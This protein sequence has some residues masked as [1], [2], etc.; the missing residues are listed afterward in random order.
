[1]RIALAADHAGFRLKQQV[2][3]HLAK[4]GHEVI[5]LG[6]DSTQPVDYPDYA[7]AAGT[8]VLEGKAERGVII[9]GSG[10][11]AAV[12]ANKLAGIRASLAHDTYT[13]H[14]A[15]EHDDLNVLA[16]GARVIGEALATEIVD[17][18]VAARFSGDERHRRR[19]A[20]LRAIEQAT[21]DRTAVPPPE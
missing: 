3:D 11:G 8:A 12:A 16:L 7:V 20:K 6:T 1:M 4:A 2:A 10:A 13:A 21:P 17:S 9:C 15:V 14:Q 18:F 19:L 5:D